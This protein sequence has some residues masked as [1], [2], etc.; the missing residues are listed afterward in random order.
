MKEQLDSEG[1]EADYLFHATGSG[2]TMAGLA[3]GKVLT[4]SETEIISAA[5]MDT[6]EDYAE[7]NAAL[8][9]RS[10]EW[11]GSDAVINPDKD[12]NIEKGYYLPGYEMPG[13]LSTE[14][15]KMMAEKE[16]ILLDPVYSG[17][18]FA[19]LVDYAGK[20]KIKPGS[21]VVFWHTGG[22]TALFAEKEILGKLY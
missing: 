8:G 4:A 19:A 2:G 10:L 13:E 9:N 11:I 18:G 7:K 15:I 20:G 1:I 22:A 12:I 14:A 17:K 5:V 6:S 16:G 21:N 3:A